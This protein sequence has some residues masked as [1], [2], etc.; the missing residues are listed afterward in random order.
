[1]TLLRQRRSRRIFIDTPLTQKE[2]IAICEAAQTAPSSCN[3]QSL[4]LIF[5]EEPGLKA[6]IA[7]TIPGGHQFFANAPCIV[8]MLS[9]AGDYKYPDDRV[10]PFMDGAAAAQNIYLLCETLDLG[11]CW[12]SYTSFG[13]VLQEPEVRARLR[14]PETHIIV[15]SLALG[16]STQ[17]VCDIPREPAEARSWDNYYGHSSICS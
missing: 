8:V 6:F 17:Y 15:A 12:G 5:V 9:D 2:K 10:T 13:T 14:I 4:S 3:R 1:M 16:K 7:S 11:C